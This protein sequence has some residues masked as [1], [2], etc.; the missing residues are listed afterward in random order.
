MQDF[1]NMS[2]DS[3]PG[4]LVIVAVLLV[5]PEAS[6]NLIG[7][8]GRF[9]RSPPPRERKVIAAE[10]C[11]YV[12]QKC[13][14]GDRTGECK[15]VDCGEN[16]M[17]LTCSLYVDELPQR[18]EILGGDG[19]HCTVEGR[20]CRGEGKQGRCRK[21]TCGEKN[22]DSCLRCLAPMD[23]DKH[24]AKLS[25]AVAFA[26]RKRVAHA[27]IQ[28]RAAQ[29]SRELGARR[30][31][32]SS[33]PTTDNVDRSKPDGSAR[34][35]ESEGDSSAFSVVSMIV[36]LVILLFVGRRTWNSG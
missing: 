19:T 2:S 27:V 33:H 21:I 22:L 29:N 13:R 32:R 5:A 12:T 11:S 35:N 30:A 15:R 23:M 1:G 9:G 31:G 17:C 4:I 24:R 16:K 14:A 36:G 6:A 34:R 10:E 20:P 8:D 25:S 28:T 26:K 18:Y 3:I 7:Y